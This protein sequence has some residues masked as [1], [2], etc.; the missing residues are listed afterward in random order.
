MADATA[1]PSFTGPAPT[2][3][4]APNAT[5]RPSSTG[6]AP[7]LPAEEPEESEVT[8]EDEPDLGQTIPDQGPLFHDLT[9]TIPMLSGPTSA[10]SFGLPPEPSTGPARVL[11]PPPAASP[12]ATADDA[13]PSPYGPGAIIGDKYRLSRVIGRGGMGAVWIAQNT[14]LEVDVAIKLMRRDRATPEATARFST[15]ARSAARLGHPSIV[16]VFDFGETSRGD[17]FIVMELLRGESFGALLTRKKRLSP[18]VAVQTLLPVAHALSA[19]HAK[20]IVHRDLKPDNIL[21]AKDESNNVVT[22]KVVDFGIAKLMTAEVDRH[23]TIAGEIL[24]SPDYMSPE[25]AKGEEDIDHRSD[26]W[27]FT[28]LLYEA[29]CGKRPFD[30]ANYNALLAAIIASRPAP[31]MDHGVPDPD[32]WSILEKG[33]TKDRDAR[34]QSVREMGT[35]L[36]RWALEHG[37]EHDLAGASLAAQWLEPTRRRLFT[38][39]GSAPPP[40][41]PPPPTA[42]TAATPV[43]DPVIPKPPPLGRLAAEV[44]KTAAPA[45]SN[46][47]PPFV[48][49]RRPWIVMGVIVGLGTGLVAVLLWGGLFD[50]PPPSPAAAPPASATS[51]PS[52]IAAE[53]PSASAPPTNATASAKPTSTAKARPAG[54]TKPRAPQVKGNIKF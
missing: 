25:Q 1:R 53:V 18:T 30:G 39:G 43:P 14:S 28:V 41:P 6:P 20:G 15:E 46:T 8:I 4:S 23:F 47:L 22:P 35:E 11:L 21:L 51:M 5:A 16:R 31:I 40:P 36:A 3:S 29:I 37:V 19:A 7:A 9:A 32:L 42:T 13:D 27:T 10:P 48:P 2:F 52:V 45:I 34:W 26:I 24:G 12:A 17:P 33:L 50:A 44:P 38:V 54:T 49:R